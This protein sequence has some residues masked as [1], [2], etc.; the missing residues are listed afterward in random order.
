MPR[1]SAVNMLLASFER[2]AMTNKRSSAGLH[3]RAGRDRHG[4]HEGM[5]WGLIPL[6]IKL[7]A[8]DTAGE[9]MVFQ[10]TNMGKGGPPRHVHHAQDEWFYVVAGEF[11]AEVGEEKYLLRVGD[12][13]FAPRQVPHAWAHVDDGPGTLITTVSPAGTFEDFIR[14]TTR[15]ATLPTEQEIARAFEAHAMKVVGPPLPVE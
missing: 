11:A 7:S 8:G 5:I 12:S 1:I 9:L 13:L 14:E 2:G 15:H 3:I 10:H 4:A 6:T